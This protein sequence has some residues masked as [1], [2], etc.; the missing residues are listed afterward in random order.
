MG[1]SG[2]TL[3]PHVGIPLGSL[4]GGASYFLLET[5]YDRPMEGARDNSGIRIFYTDSLRENDAAMM[6][7]GSEVNFMHA[8]PPRQV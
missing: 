2:E 6:L 1:H 5:H 3:P 7:L 4:H 8:I